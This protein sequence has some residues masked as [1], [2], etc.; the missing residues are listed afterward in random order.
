MKELV[1]FTLNGCY[2]CSELKD[3]LKEAEISFHDIEIT[4]N[5][6]LWDRVVEQ[7]G[8]DV[9][10]TVFIQ[11]DAEGNGSVYIPGRDFQDLNEIMKIIKVEI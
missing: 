4:R 10:P 2:H 1:V 6:P 7:T 3:K 5:K 11:T 9:L 8:H